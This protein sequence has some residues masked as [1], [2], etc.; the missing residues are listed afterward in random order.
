MSGSDDVAYDP[1][2]HRQWNLLGD[3]PDCC[4]VLGDP[5][6]ELLARAESAGVA[7]RIA[8]GV[9]WAHVLHQGT[10]A[11]RH[12]GQS[13]L[14]VVQRGQAPASPASGRVRAVTGHLGLAPAVFKTMWG[15]AKAASTTA[16]I[17]EGDLVRIRSSGELATVR[18]VRPRMGEFEAVVD[19][20]RGLQTLDASALDV[21][22]GDPRDPEFWITQG[23]GSA[24]DLALTIT[25]TKLRH[26]L[27][28]TIYS[29]A[30]SK[31]I[32][33]PYQFAPVLKLLGSATGRLLIADEVGLGKTI[34]AGLIWSELE[35]RTK[36]DRVLVVAP[37]SLALKWK[38]EM[39]RRFDRDLDVMK[40]ADLLGIAHKMAA[41]RE[42]RFAGVV[43]IESLRSATE[44]LEAL[45]DVHARLD[46]VIVD[47][48]H[49]LRNRGRRGYVMGQLLSDWADVL[50]FLSATPLNLG[51]SDLFNLV[52]MLREDEFSDEAVFAA[53]LEP[54]QALNTIARRLRYDKDEPR[55]LLAVAD[56]IST[57]QLG[58]AVTARPDFQR[59]R[60]VLDSDGPLGH[61]EIA[62]AKRAV[63]DLNTLG[64]V[65]TRTRKVDVPDAKAIRVAEQIV[66]EWTP[67][68]RAVYD[69][70]QQRYMR[71]FLA[72]GTPPG[73]GMQMPLRQA[74]SCLP[75]MQDVLRNK[76]RSLQ[77]EHEDEDVDVADEGEAAAD[78]VVDPSLSTLPELVRPL[79]VDSKLEAMVARLAELRAVG[80]RQVMIFSFFK[81]TLSYLEDKLAESFAVRRMTGVTPM[82]QRQRTMDDFR[83]GKFDLLLLSQVGAEG[84]DFEFCNALV[85]YD[86]PWNPMQVEQRIGRLDRFGQ[87]NEKIFIYN[88]HVPGTIESD[89]FER[90]YTRIGLFE[91]SIGELEPILRDELKSMTRALLDPRLSESQRSAEAE[92][93]AVALAERAQLVQQLEE[94]RGALSTVD[95]LQVDGMTEEGPSDGRFVGP[96]EVRRLV[97]RLLARCGGQLSEPSRT[98]I[99]RLVGSEELA[100]V[101]RTSHARRSGSMKTVV[102]L[103]A[104]LRDEVKIRVTF[105]SDVAS[106]HEV[107]LI[108]S[109]H[110]LVEVALQVLESSDLSLRR[111]GIVAIPDLTGPSDGYLA[112]LDLAQTTGLRPQLELW[113]TA[114]DLTSGQV[115]QDLG[116]ALLEATARGRL[117]DSSE[118]PRP[119]LRQ[120]L[121]KLDDAVAVRRRDLQLE[122]RADNDAL[123]DARIASQ[124]RSIDLKIAKAQATLREVIERQRDD[125]VIRLHQGRI[126]NLRTDRDAVRDE[127]QS[128]RELHVSL[129]PVAVLQ[130]HPA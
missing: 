127:L 43:S 55:K 126:S 18:S 53:Q 60:E 45:T 1:S 78:A 21:V 40:P 36:L 100:R 8:D 27:T 24:E 7:V 118:S 68:E 9:D 108:S 86:L 116:G 63:A 13:A 97:E 88:M 23:S 75:A 106:K 90:L 105:D 29:F 114:V 37:A 122:R 107:E 6:E 50:V 64:S 57:M 25:W 113:V 103:A 47:E 72:R 4:L 2:V 80:I 49:A 102:Q 130:V 44:T 96:S 77:E 109:R 38:S 74:A 56:T 91:Q 115:V 99:C 26:P 30:S 32:F 117:V 104:E 70:I 59:L 84:L 3:A 92:R 95:Q 58:K 123:V 85:N 11:L 79:E 98:G 83:A 48:A 128:R 54:N 61:E 5:T 119:D 10:Y 111:F 129:T 20:P 15:S 31:T 62:R 46:L 69:G 12:D 33:R 41:G 39:A 76:H 34:E 42:A 125:R 67:Q 110:P 82:D 28:D 124:L 66:V 52:N 94:A 17:A 87:T 19:G 51:Q 81:G 120:L 121:S 14:L 16:G 112:K 101:V 22:E 65:L 73:F 89:I 35:Q 93:V 71:E